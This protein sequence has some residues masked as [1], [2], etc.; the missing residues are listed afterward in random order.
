M[1]LVV[2]ALLAGAYIAFGALFSQVVLAG[3]E[4]QAPFGVVK[5]LS[6]AAFS[7][8]LILVVVGGAELF[9]GNTL[10]VI[11]RA[12]DKATTV[13]IA[14]AWMIV[15]LGNLVGSLVIV[16]LFVLAG[17]HTAG[18]GQVGLA[19]LKTAQAKTSLPLLEV[20]ASGVLAN[21]LVCL[22][23]WLSLGART[24]P[25]KI[26]AI[27]FPITAFVAAGLEHSV[28]NMSLIPLG[29]LVLASGADSFWN[30]LA[31]SA[32]AFPELSLRGFGRNL[33]ASTLGNIVGGA[34]IGMAYW[35]AYR[36]GKVHRPSPS[37]A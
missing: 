13:E 19:A 14:R 35:F 22:A 12:S 3:A 11:P 28:A 20:M 4:G 5:L 31:L 2:L 32:D 16:I 34:T 33:L 7:L 10:M 6:G 21:M 17:G 30:D 8:G 26:L 23:V 24:I 1:N 18:D 9:T 37:S 15:Y 27:I 29:L 36:R 25:G